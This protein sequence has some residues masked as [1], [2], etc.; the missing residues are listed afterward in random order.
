MP[1][2]E[3][4]Q[5]CRNPRM[6]KLMILLALQTKKLKTLVRGKKIWENHS[7][8]TLKTEELVQRRKQN[9]THRSEEKSGTRLKRAMRR[10]VLGLRRGF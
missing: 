5:K 7:Y 4:L 6:G 8:K 3:L 1:E 10:L 2:Q 9:H